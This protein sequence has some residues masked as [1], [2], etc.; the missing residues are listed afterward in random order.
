MNL[1]SNACEAMTGVDVRSRVVRIE[2]RVEENRVVVTVADKG[3]GLPADGA[4]TLFDAFYTTKEDGM[5]MGLAIS[6]T[7][8]E[9]H[10]GKIEARS[11]QDG[12]ATLEFALPVDKGA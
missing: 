5:G 3:T 6:R 12:G 9:A 1:L 7:I 8:I 11:N 10:A 2:T 4:D